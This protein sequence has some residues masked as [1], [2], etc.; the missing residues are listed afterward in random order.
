[1]AK[2]GTVASKHSFKPEL[3]GLLREGLNSKI[4]SAEIVSG[5]VKM[6]TMMWV[7]GD[8]PWS[9]WSNQG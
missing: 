8:G 7:D 1:M 5:L 4:V 2:R 9:D 3:E 6:D